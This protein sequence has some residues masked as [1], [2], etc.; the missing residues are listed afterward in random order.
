MGA[1]ADAF[2]AFAQPLIDQTD[3][4]PEQLQKALTLSQLCYNAALLPADQREEMFADCRS[5]LGMNDDEFDDFQRSILEPMIARHEQMFPLLHQ[6]RRALSSA[7]G[8]SSWIEPRSLASE[9]RAAAP[10]KKSTVDRYAPCPCG[11]GKKYKFCC[12][13]KTR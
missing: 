4:S 1:M 3:G 13:A 11:S 7:G 5:S 2:A 10:A 12:G 8:P 6:R 9:P